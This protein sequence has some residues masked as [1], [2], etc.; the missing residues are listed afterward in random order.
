MRRT[1]TSFRRRWGAL[2][3]AAGLTASLL[4]FTAAVAANTVTVYYQPPIAWGSSVNIHYGVDGAAWTPVP[5]VA[6]DTACAGW[7]RRTI[8]LGTAS[9][10]QVVFT[11]GTGVWD[12]NNGVNYRL[13]TGT[14]TVAAGK[15]GSGDPCA[16]NTQRHVHRRGDRGRPD[17]RQRHPHRLGQ[18]QG[19]PA[20][21][22]A[23]P[24]RQPGAGED[25]RGRAVPEVTRPR[26]PRQRRRGGPDAR[27][28]TTAGPSAV[29]EWWP[30]RGDGPAGREERPVRRRRGHRVSCRS[31]PP[32]RG[33][34]G[35]PGP[36][37]RRP[38]RPW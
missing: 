24:A 37:R 38:R 35:R 2:A 6:M 19:Q 10:L 33:G 26:P 30:R 17:R 8:D 27:P 21:L 23:R 32:G 28:R 9:G 22:R 15:V 31:Y 25:R 18:R 5:G 34:P 16:T 20:R 29:R 12:N 14:V 4:P 13:G 7:R 36:G 1:T 3:L 11:N